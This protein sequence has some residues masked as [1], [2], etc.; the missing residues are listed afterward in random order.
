MKYYLFFFAIAIFNLNL[1]SQELQRRPNLGLSIKPLTEQI[2]KQLNYTGSAKAYVKRVIPGASGENL[3][4]LENDILIE[5]GGVRVVKGFYNQVKSKYRAGDEISAKVFRDGKVVEL[6]GVLTATPKET[7]EYADIIYDSVDFEGKLRSILYLPKKRTNK[8]LPV[9]FYVQG[10]SCASM[11][12]VNQFNNSSVHQLINGFVQKG[13]A[14]YRVEKLGMG[15][16]K[17]NLTCTEVDVNTE[18]NGFREALKRLKKTEHI[19]NEEIYIWGHSLGASHA[20]FI[21]RDI[22]VKGI[23]GYGFVAKSWHD[24]LIDIITLQLPLLEDLTYGD[25][26]GKMDDFRMPLHELFYSDDALEDII[27]R[28]PKEDMDFLFS[29]FSYDGKYLLGRSPV[30]LRSLNKLNLVKEFQDIKTPTLSLYGESDLAAIGGEMA[31]KT[32]ADAINQVSPGNG[33]YKLIPLTNHHLSKVGSIEDNVKVLN[34]KKSWQNAKI[35]FNKDIIE[36]THN[37]ILS[38]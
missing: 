36:I 1:N 24:Y 26:Q 15:D 33:Y 30:F 10:F 12:Q 29:V 21:A 6:K 2:S 19:N 8:N 34:E 20:P 13:Y 38:L 37:W 16:S 28:Y 25:V 14:V 7:S 27:S 4:F 35:N 18:I 17:N 5:I 3:K 31:V 9:I 23:I 11:E 32:I 22:G